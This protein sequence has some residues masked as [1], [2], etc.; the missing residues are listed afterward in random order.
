MSSTNRAT[1]T[2]RP[3]GR[4]HDRRRREQGVARLG[5]TGS[6]GARLNRARAGTVRGH[7]HQGGGGGGVPASASSQAD[8]EAGLRWAPR[9][10]TA[11]PGWMR[12]GPSGSGQEG[13]FCF[14]RIYFNAKTI[15]E[16]SRNCLKARK[17]L[18]KPQKF[19][20]TSKS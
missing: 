17:I 8:M 3:A 4:L 12:V 13:R 6:S 1:A 2:H 5:S 19:Q 15:P 9:R 10:P 11:G 7:T 20:E 16:K 14:F 18:R